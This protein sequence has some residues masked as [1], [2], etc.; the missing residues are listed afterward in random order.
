MEGKKDDAI[1]DACPPAP[2]VT[3]TRRKKAWGP[4]QVS[5]ASHPLQKDEQTEHKPSD[6]DRVKEEACQITDNNEKKH[7]PA[8]LEHNDRR[9]HGSQVGLLET[10]CDKCEVICERG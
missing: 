9:G 2:S 7:Q 5:S 4:E 1:E 8:N 3:T 6:K 10:Q